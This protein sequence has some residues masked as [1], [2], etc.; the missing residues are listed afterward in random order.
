V[1]AALLL[2]A[3][4]RPA[5]SQAIDATTYPFTFATGATLEDMSSG[6][7]QL[8]GPDLDNAVSSVVPMGLE[9]WF[10]GTRY[11]NFSVNSNGLLKPGSSVTQSAPANNLAS[12][13]TAPQIAPYW[14]HLQ[15]GTNGKVHFKLV[16]TAPNRKMVVEWLNMQ[17]PRVGSGSPGSATFQCWLYESTGQIEFVYGGGLVTNTLEGGAS[18]GIGSPAGT[19]ASVTALYPSVAYGTANNANVTPIAS[20]TRYTFTP[21]VPAAP[22]GLSFSSVGALGMTL[23]WA[24]NASNEVG[25]AV[26]RSTDGVNYEFVTQTAANITSLV[27]TGLAPATTY[28]WIVRA[29]TEGALSALL[30]GSQA[31][32]AA[33][34]ITSAGS[35]NWSSTVP[36]APWPGGIVPSA[37]DAVTVADGHTVTVDAT[38]N[39]LSL[40]VGQGTSGALRFETT[41]ARS[42]TVVGGVTVSAGAL[43]ASAA[44]GTQTGHVLSLGGSL[45][46][47]GMLDLS[48]GGNLAGATLAFTGVADASFTGNGPVTNIRALTASK[49]TGATLTLDAPGFSVRGQTADT[50]G[51]LTL[52][53]GTFHLAG[54]FTMSSKVFTTPAYSLPAG[55][56]FWLDN[57]N[58]TVVPQAGSATVRGL[59]ISAGVFQV[60]TLAD[61]S[62]QLASGAQVTVEGGQVST[63]GRFA[64]SA[65]S[66]TVAYSQTGGTVTVNTVGN[67]ST[68]LASFDLGVAATSSAAISGGTIVIQKAS[69]AGSGP[70]DFRNGA[71]TQSLTGGTLQLG[72][73]STGAPGTYLL[74]GT[75]PNLLVSNLSGGHTARL[76]G[77]TTVVGATQIAP[78]A[79]LDL[80]GFRFTQ[81][82]GSLANDGTLTGAATGS[83]LYFLGSATPQSYSGA[84][85][86]PS[87]VAILSVDN[88]AGVSIS[89]SLAANI[90]TRRVNLIRGVL[91][92]SQKI[93]LGNGNADTL[94]AITQL[95]GSGVTGAAGAYDASPVFNP[96]TGGVAV[97]YLQEGSPR[98]T[99][100]EIPATRL[101]RDLAINNPGGVVTLSGGAVTLARGLTLS[102]GLLHT[103]ASD[104]VVLGDTA[105]AI[106]AGSS[107]SYVDGPL[108]IAIT[109]LD[110]TT[111]GRS[112]AVGRDGAFRPL[113]LSGVLTG[114]VQQVLTAEV[115][116]GPTGGTPAAPLQ[117]L[118][119]TRYWR[120]GNSAGLNPS[121]RV[122]LAFGTDDKVGLL[123][124]LRVAQSSTAAG[125]YADLGGTATGSPASGTVI[126]TAN[127]TP[128]S[129]YLVVGS[130]GALA[131]TW[132]GGA[133]TSN[134][135]DAAN[136]SPDGV[137]DST[138][139]VTL[140][141]ATPATINVAGLFSV[142]HLTVNS[143]A[144]LQAS[145]GTL[146]VTG[147]YSQQSGSNVQLVGGALTVRGYTTLAGGTLD[148]GAGTFTA[149]DY[150]S[151]PGGS[152]NIGSGTFL[153]DSS[154]GIE[155][156][157]VSMTT[158]TLEVKGGFWRTAGNYFAGTGTTLF[159][160]TVAQFIGGGMTHY[161]LVL[162]NGGAGFPKSFQDFVSHTVNN[163]MTVESTAQMAVSGASTTQL[164]V[165]GNFHYSGLTGGTSIANMTLNLAGIGKTVGGSTVLAAAEINSAEAQSAAADVPVVETNFLTD[166]ARAR[167]LGRDLDG[168]PLIVLENTYEKKKAEVEQL[169]QSADPTKRLVINLDDMTLVRNPEVGSASPATAAATSTLPMPVNVAASASY[170][171]DGNLTMASSRILTISGRLDCGTFTLGGTGGRVTVSSLGTLGT[172]TTSATGLAATVLTTGTNTYSDG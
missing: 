44:S 49:G 41:T 155:G 57:P 4:T 137:P 21:Q 123:A 142:H 111:A 91:G 93:T 115:L 47:Q 40:T 77:A 156:G 3:W 72:N 97:S 159:S 164:T 82:V 73:A 6:T 29:V 154:F 70:R 127:L 92:N 54:S 45:T 22:T 85:T 171:L 126:S 121:A 25:Y 133:G 33:G 14:D 1:V 80:N 165:W 129:D 67:P 95:G 87:P 130:A 48:T 62:L 140:S 99:G 118:T 11:T 102:A 146:T 108:A 28:Y 128:G 105:S 51:F 84:G 79:T 18:I 74:S 112:F 150:V 16:G 143:H 10:A 101:L 75:I 36:G 23:A 58:F 2:G 15:V 78:G 117:A 124:S 109:T 27:Q 9:F 32:S 46:N 169:L 132:D 147:D 172:A 34:A 55:T 31:T 83:E 90:V 116:A 100:F 168:K 153:A 144:T 122:Q 81:S 39:C 163:D 98:T 152:L 160:G 110:T 96:G 19:F 125:S 113:A 86:V 136:W 69:T 135:G 131:S 64:V 42:L 30:S 50:L 104:V 38:A 12:I 139:D 76:T 158:G 65:S 71:G 157:S 114:G 166:P 148:L 61:H 53:S 145:S 59:R 151:I 94:S 107:Q 37:S 138:T 52:S 66:N 162:R 26:W 7:T 60:G 141:L 120:L 89:A 170:A 119:G 134:W 43:L 35:G 106:P 24:D 8:V 56:T 103:T 13:L 17:V 161:N 5:A 149:R 167:P 63:A 68:S 20:G 88:P